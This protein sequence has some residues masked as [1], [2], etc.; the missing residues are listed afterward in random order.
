VHAQ[1]EGCDFLA[2]THPGSAMKGSRPRV[3]RSQ[4]RECL[5]ATA[6]GLRRSEERLQ[7]GHVER[8]EGLTGQFH[9]PGNGMLEDIE[10]A[11]EASSRLVC[12]ESAELE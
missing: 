8:V 9:P 6:S 5:G 3:H 12:P 10:L 4:V 1:E 7:A 11:G 2:A